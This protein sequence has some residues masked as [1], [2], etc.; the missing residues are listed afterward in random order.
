MILSKLETGLIGLIAVLG[1][2]F[3]LVL[4]GMRYE[5]NKQKAI[6]ATALAN[7]TAQLAQAKQV[8]KDLTQKLARQKSRATVVY[9]TITHYIPKQEIVYVNSHPQTGSVALT[10]N[11][12]WLFNSSTLG[13][14]ALPGTAA[15]VA[16]SSADSGITL[17]AFVGTVVHN[18]GVCLD[19]RRQLQ[20]LIQFWRTTAPGR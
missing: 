17:Q 5:A 6:Y 18:A 4:F 11:D 3:G 14:L 16:G 15:G 8:G 7:K 19:N 9:K 1:V 10:D 13:S 12:A 20:A 2:L